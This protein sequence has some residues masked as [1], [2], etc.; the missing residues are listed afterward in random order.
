MGRWEME[1][2]EERRRERWVKMIV[3][4]MMMMMTVMSMVMFIIRVFNFRSN[5]YND[6]IRKLYS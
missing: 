4:K 1:E 6:D 3:R 2:G 5:D